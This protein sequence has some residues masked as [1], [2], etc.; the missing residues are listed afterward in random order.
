MAGVIHVKRIYEPKSA[1]DGLRVLV[2]RLWPRGV[3]KATATV[4]VWM[5]DVAPSSNLRRWFGHKPDRWEEFQQ[6][7]RNELA[8]NLALVELRRLAA[9]SNLTLLYAAKDQ[10]HNHAVVLADVLSGQPAD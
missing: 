9:M 2:D 3:T 10:L 8:G 4:D 6:R 1:A 7:Y 5:R